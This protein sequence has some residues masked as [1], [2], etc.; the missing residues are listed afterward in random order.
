VSL[1]GQLRGATRDRLEEQLDMAARGRR[2][3]AYAALLGAF[4]SV[5]GPVKLA[6]G[7]YPATG[8]VVPD[9]PERVKTP[10]L[11][12][13]LAQLEVA[14]PADGPTV[15]VFCAEEVIGTVYVFKDATL[16]GAAV[17]RALAEGDASLP[18]RFFTSYGQRRGV[19]W[20]TFRRRAG[21][22]EQ[23]N[24]Q[25]ELAVDAPRRTFAAYDDACRARL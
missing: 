20:R 11:D 9:W 24:P 21:E 23:R 25:R 7:S 15:Q 10:W 22:F 4:R 18:C 6:V 19:M 5:Y 12:E 1:L 13:D 2:P 14:A 8:E 17:V 16:G 3:S